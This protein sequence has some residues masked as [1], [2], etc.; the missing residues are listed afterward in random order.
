MTAQNITNKMPWYQ[1]IIITTGITTTIIM[2]ILTLFG[3]LC[4]VN[5]PFLTLTISIFLTCLLIIIYMILYIYLSK[6]PIKWKKNNQYILIKCTN[7]Y[8]ISNFLAII[9]IL[10]LPHVCNINISPKSRIKLNLV[11]DYLL[12]DAIIIIDKKDYGTLNTIDEIELDSGCHTIRIEH[13]ED[14]K[15]KIFETKQ[16][17][18]KDTPIILN[19]NKFKTE[20]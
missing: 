18:Y 20:D 7:L 9:I 8:V 12:N 10:W 15:I 5:I 2:T 1:I 11:Y 3:L 14:D 13:R 19:K 4:H 6:H 16:T 17:F